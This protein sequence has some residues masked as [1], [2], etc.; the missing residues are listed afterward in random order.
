MF[1]KVSARIFILFV[2]IN[3]ETSFALDSKRDVENKQLDEILSWDSDLN[4]IKTYEL[5]MTKKT[6]DIFFRL[7]K[8]LKSRTNLGNLKKYRQARFGLWGRDLIKS[9]FRGRGQSEAHWEKHNK[10]IK[11]RFK[12]GDG[13]TKKMNFN[14]LHSDPYLLDMIAYK[15]YQATGL[16][17][18]NMEF[19]QLVINGEYNGIKQ[20]L[21]NINEEFLERLKIPLGNIYKEKKTTSLD[22]FYNWVPG[23]WEMLWQKETLKKEN[24]YEDWV[25]FHEINSIESDDIFFRYIEKYLDI[26]YYLK[27]HALT[28]LIAGTGNHGHNFIFVNDF[29]SQKIKQVGYDTVPFDKLLTT[30]P[31]YFYR[32]QLFSRIITKPEYY[33]KVIKHMHDFLQDSFKE[34]LFEI[35]GEHLGV[36]SKTIKD[37]KKVIFNPVKNSYLQSDFKN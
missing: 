23:N 4:L 27:W 15:L 13:N 30:M 37:H 11:I 12:D 8:S 19:S 17:A 36:L 3:V 2:L 25:S 22:S 14:S 35:A 16:L 9:K 24:N 1:A 34:R 28:N 26:D 21:E 10:S 6:H 18:P 31:T 33:F 5:E 29:R 20:R 7:T 32:D